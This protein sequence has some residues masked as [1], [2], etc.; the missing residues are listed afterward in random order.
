MWIKTGETFI[1]A[2]LMTQICLN[3]TES[4]KSIK[5]Y[6]GPRDHKILQETGFSL[7][8][9]IDLGFFSIIAYPLLMIIQILYK[10][11]GNYG[12]AIVLLTLVIKM[13]FLP[14]TSSSIKSMKKMQDL[15]PLLIVTLVVLVS[16]RLIVQTLIT[17]YK[18]R[19]IL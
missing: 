3:R 4:Q 1:T 7:E 13:I 10:F 6:V 14:L 18:S 12:L 19:L 17:L 9:S 5:I 11:L 16:N 8:R 15:Q 2:L